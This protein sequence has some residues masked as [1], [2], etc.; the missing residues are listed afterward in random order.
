[1]PDAE[2]PQSKCLIIHPSQDYNL[3]LC[4]SYVAVKDTN[5]SDIQQNPP[6][7][8]MQSKQQKR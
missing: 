5:P 4:P 1:M 3:N 8:K 2:D 6:N 7:Q